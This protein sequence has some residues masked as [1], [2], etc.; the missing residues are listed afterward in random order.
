MKSVTIAEFK[1]RLPELLE[2]VAKGE[3]IVLQ[4]GRRR[5]N[6][7]ILAPFDGQSLPSRKLGLLSSRGKPTFKDWEI[8]EED[9]LSSGT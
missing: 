1:N 9:F 2:E 3:R 5:T 6:V 8:T 7:A 4:K